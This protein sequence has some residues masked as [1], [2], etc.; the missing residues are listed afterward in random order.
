MYQIQPIEIETR[1]IIKYSMS[2]ISPIL[3]FSNIQR[4]IENVIQ[5]YT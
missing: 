5:E 1:R 2:H 3:I 4:N